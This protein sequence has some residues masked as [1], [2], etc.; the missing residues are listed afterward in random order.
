MTHDQ[1]APSVTTI[2][3]D[4]SGFI[5]IGALPATPTV[6][7]GIGATAGGGADGSAAPGSRL[8]I[9]PAVTPA[10]GPTFHADRGPVPGRAFGICAEGPPK[11]AFVPTPTPR[12]SNCAGGGG[13]GHP[14]APNWSG[15]YGALWV[16]GTTGGNG[17]N[18]GGSALAAGAPATTA[19]PTAATHTLVLITDRAAFRSTRQIT[20]RL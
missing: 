3:L 17:G 18:G 20:T 10:A 19:N 16:P 1:F 6:G 13:I 5:P 11:S 15:P 2:G 7:T 12:A 9:E 8:D 14:G 4:G